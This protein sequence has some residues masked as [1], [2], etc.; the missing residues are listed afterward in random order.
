MDEEI[1]GIECSLYSGRI[2]KL[3]MY[4][5]DKS[6]DYYISWC[7][8][9]DDWHN[10]FPQS[11][12]NFHIS[13]QGLKELAQSSLW[14]LVL[15]IY[16]V[17]Q[18]HKIIETYSDFENSSCI[19]CLILYD[20]GLLDIYVKD[21]NLLESIYNQLQSLQAEELRILTNRSNIRKILLP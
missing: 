8:K 4:L 11:S 21:A 7:M 19:C 1:K 20:C 16:P 10:S 3:L 12:Q 6:Y 9:I 18:E 5:A 15:Y 2:K 17:G 13:T 14:E